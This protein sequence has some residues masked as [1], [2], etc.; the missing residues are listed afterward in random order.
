MERG[1]R[2]ERGRED[3]E[4]MSLAAADVKLVVG[5]SLL[6]IGWSLTWTHVGPQLDPREE[7]QLKHKQWTPV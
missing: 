4:M 7:R 3:D 1:E 6:R 5:A 2:G